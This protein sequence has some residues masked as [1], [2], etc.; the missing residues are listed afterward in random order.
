MSGA[1]RIG[2]VNIVTSGPVADGAG[3]ILAAVRSGEARTR[4][5]LVAHTGFA[6]GTV[7]RRLELLLEAGLLVPAEDSEATGGRPSETFAV[8]P[9]TG[10]L[11]VADVGASRARLAVCDLLGTIVAERELP[12][13]VAAGPEPVLRLLHRTWASLLEEAPTNLPTVRGV[14]V[15]VPG[16]VD[17]AT[18]STVSPP[19][20]T[21][22]DRYPIRDVLS[23]RYGCLAWVENDVNAMALGE[24]RAVRSDDPAL[25][26]V[27]LGT[28]VG[29]GLVLGGKVFRG[30]IGAAGDIGHL[31]MEGIEQRR[32]RCGN[33]G[34]VEAIAGGWALRQQLEEHGIHT[35]NTR[36]IVDLVRHGEPT[37]VELVRRAARVMGHAISHA[38]NLINPSVVVIGGDLAHA[39]EQLLAGMREVVYKHS[40]PLA[41]ANLEFVTSELDRRAGV[42]GLANLVADQLLDPEQLDRRL[43]QHGDWAGAP[44]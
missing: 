41:T 42:V 16:P 32:C 36:E 31:Q 4:R 38:V 11:L 21:G 19:I 3:R 7:A 5:A 30:A 33:A 26:Y 40:L 1:V 12:M 34:C 15:G 27:K 25:L 44:S 13:D 23:E 22:W 2:K 6:R 10:S 29:A 43:A 8:N 28:G 20:M 24:H 17:Q 18:G 9:A 37:A 14:G 39:R 35:S